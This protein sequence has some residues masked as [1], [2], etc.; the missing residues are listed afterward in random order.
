[1]SD[2]NGMRINEPLGFGI[3]SDLSQIFRKVLQ[4]NEQLAANIKSILG[5]GL[6][7]NWNEA[8]NQA[9]RQMEGQAD[10]VKR[11][12]ASLTQ[13]LNPL[14]DLIKR[15]DLDGKAYADA[16]REFRFQIDLPK[17][18]SQHLSLHIKSVSEAINR[19]ISVPAFFQTSQFTAL[20]ARMAD[21]ETFRRGLMEGLGQAVEQMES[22]P[23]ARFSPDETLA[24]LQQGIDQSG[25]AKREES[26]ETVLRSFLLWLQSNKGAAVGIIVQLLV[27]SI[28]LCIEYSPLFANRRNSS[29]EDTTRD[30]L[31]L[32]RRVTE[33]ILADKQVPAEY[34]RTFRLVAKDGLQ[35][36]LSYRRDSERIATLTTGQVVSIQF[37]RKNWC[38]V[39][40]L[41]TSRGDWRTGW[42]LTRYLEKLRD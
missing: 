8:F 32:I 40:W 9:L 25:I 27:G 28:L 12:A 11:I 37:K 18:A 31:R 33:R 23:D 3:S 21:E 4:E 13:T 22:F 10:A 24:L 35:V 39:A 29:A 38:Q 16:L 36:H 20:L 5:G 15:L 17:L 41:D 7:N 6:A 42:T 26:C 14:P 1:M 2:D 30:H 34:R 19:A